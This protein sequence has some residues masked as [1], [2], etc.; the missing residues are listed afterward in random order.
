[1]IKKYHVAEKP[2][3]AHPAIVGKN[4]LIKDEAALAVWSLD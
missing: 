2:T 4:I 3:W 1:V